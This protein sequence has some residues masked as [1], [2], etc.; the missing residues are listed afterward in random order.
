MRFHY[1]QF[2][3]ARFTHSPPR[4]QNFTSRGVARELSVTC[5]D[6]QQHGYEAGKRDKWANKRQSPASRPI[7]FPLPLL[8]QDF[9]CALSKPAELREW[10]G[11]SASRR[12]NK[13]LLMDPQSSESKFRLPSSPSLHHCR[14]KGVQSLPDDCLQDSGLSAH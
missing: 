1:K 13:Q 7:S 5:S 3:A 11:A 12:F 8:I 14:K 2:R 6:G 10:S 4:S 9:A